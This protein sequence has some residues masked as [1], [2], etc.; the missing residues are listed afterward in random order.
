MSR[1]MFGTSNHRLKTGRGKNVDQTQT[2]P[3]ERAP[4][5]RPPGISRDCA[6]RLD[7]VP[8]SWSDR[9]LT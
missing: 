4:F 9:L 8:N 1:A 5:Q 2:C 6:V 3:L 7:F